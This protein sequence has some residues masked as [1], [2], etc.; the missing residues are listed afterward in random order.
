MEELKDHINNE[1]Y[2]ECIEFIK[3]VRKSRCNNTLIRHLKKFNWLCHQTQSGCSNHTGGHP[4][5]TYT[6][7][8]ATATV[9]TTQTTVTTLQMERWVNNLLGVPLTKAQVSLFAHGSNFGVAPRHPPFGENIATVEQ[10][11]QSLGP[12]EAEEIRAEIRG[13]QTHM[14]PGKTLPKKKPRHL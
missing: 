9:T 7:T 10:A 8:P 2:E 3:N 1:L 13:P 4:K 14:P 6:L 5:N 12:H 11:W